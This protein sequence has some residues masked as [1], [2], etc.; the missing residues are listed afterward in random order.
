MPRYIEQSRHGLFYLRLPK[1]LA[2]LNQGKRVSLHT[3]SKRLAIQRANRHISSLNLCLS[4]AVSDPIPTSLSEYQ[5]LKLELERDFQ[6]ENQ[7]LDQVLQ[8]AARLPDSS[9]AVKLVLEQRLRNVL[10]E[11][12]TRYIAQQL[13]NTALTPGATVDDQYAILN[14]LLNHAENI[15]LEISGVR[16]SDGSISR[17]TLEQAKSSFRAEI[18]SKHEEI[19][20]RLVSLSPPS[21]S[22]QETGVTALTS[23]LV[24]LL[25]LHTLQQ[26]DAKSLQGPLNQ[27]TLAEYERYAR[28]LTVLSNRKPIQHFTQGDI[29][30]LHKAVSHVE[31][32]AVRY[33]NVETAKVSDLIPTGKRSY[34]CIS[35][36]TASTYS[37]RLHALHLFAYKKGYTAIRPDKIDKPRFAKIASKL[38]KATPLDDTKAKSYRVDELQAIFNGYLY[39][40][41]ELNARK[42]I[43]PYQFWL[44]LIGIYSGMR[45]DEVCGLS[46]RAVEQSKSGIWHFKIE[47]QLALNRKLKNNASK[48]RVPVHKDLIA[49]GF[50]DYVI[51]RKRRKAVMLFDGL[52]Y[53]ANGWGNAATR[54]FTRLPSDTSPGT[55]YLFDVGVHLKKHDGRDYHAF[56]H[57]FIDQLRACGV[58]S[59]YDIEAITGHEKEDVSEADRYGDGPELGEKADKVNRV[60]YDLDLSHISYELFKSHYSSALIRSLRS[61]E[62]EK[63]KQK[64]MSKTQE[65]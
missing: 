63:K 52:H 6:D 34:T 41:V 39:C 23:P 51:E 47:E 50:I 21:S 54:F 22:G 28:V 4:L 1:H 61:F 64:N 45:I 16:Q 5:A 40:P 58:D 10:V 13:E 32:G 57:T 26:V 43:H 55:G 46:A 19:A 62:K 59:G 65:E 33:L 53:N 24:T 49:L 36:E 17:S 20:E 31:L 56:R 15:E 11:E 3:H 9:N 12:A 27:S 48:R 25:G 7:K 8:S 42:E 60:T 37:V 35:P 2:H 38:R 30:D 29:E 14:A 44:P 18:Y